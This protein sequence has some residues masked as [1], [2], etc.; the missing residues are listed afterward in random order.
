MLRRA[1]ELKTIRPLVAGELQSLPFDDET[2]DCV[3]AI[4]VIQHIPESE[5]NAA[6]KELVR[7]VKRGGYIVLL[8]V[9][10]DRAAHV[11]PHAPGEWI[12]RMRSCGLELIDRFGEEFLPFDRAFKA[13]I[14]LGKK[15]FAQTQKHDRSVPCE[16]E[17]S[18]SDVR[19]V[20]RQVYWQARRIFM[21]LSVWTEPLASRICSP[22]WAT[23]AVFVFRKPGEPP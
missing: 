5:Q 23:H 13:V 11:F 15:P 21:S 20:S 22:N 4:T 17:K 3:S 9:T 2:F 19:R 7:M 1:L 8:E 12:A 16:I 10:R 14:S 6:T 18:K